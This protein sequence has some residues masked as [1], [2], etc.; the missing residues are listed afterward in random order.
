[1]NYK[2]IKKGMT[3]FISENPGFNNKL[4]GEVLDIDKDQDAQTNVAGVEYINIKVYAERRIQTWPSSR[5]TTSW[6]NTHDVI[7]YRF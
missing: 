6:A 4:P 5:L 1:M 7:S 2:E 3:V